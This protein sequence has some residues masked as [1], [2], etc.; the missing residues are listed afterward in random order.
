ML[1]DIAPLCLLFCGSGVKG[2]GVIVCMYLSRFFIYSSFN[3]L[4][5]MTPEYYPTSIRNFGLGVNNSFSRIGGLLSPFAAV[6]ARSAPWRYAPEAIFAALSLVAGSLVL[7]LPPDK[8]GKALDDCIE[9]VTH[10]P[11]LAK[12]ASSLFGGGGG[13]KRSSWPGGSSVVTGQQ[14]HQA[15]QGVS[16]SGDDASTLVEE[17]SAQGLLPTP[18][19]K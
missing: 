16:A 6:N 4:W 9:D 17:G 15:Q 12:R 3:I 8:K 18:C 14:Q 19:A 10:V 1:P 2:V 11:E 5:A 7:L 13:S